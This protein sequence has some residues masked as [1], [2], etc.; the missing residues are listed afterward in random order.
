MSVDDYVALDRADEQ[1]WEYVNGEAYAMAGGTTEHA[2]VAGNLHVALRAALEGKPCLAF[3]EAQKIATVR[4]PAYHYPD[5]SVVCPPF[6]KDA[7]DENALTSPVALFEVLSPATRNY[8]QGDKFAHYRSIET[9]T[10]YVLV[11]LDAR[12]V[13]HRRKLDGGEWLSSYRTEGAVTLA[14]LGITLPIEALWKDLDRLA[15]P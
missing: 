13:E 14:S 10:D 9:L 8:D 4:T 15:A 1:R 11:D 3:H 2:L 6:T 7:R 12:M 5:A